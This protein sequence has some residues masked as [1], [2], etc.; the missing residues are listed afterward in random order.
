[1]CLSGSGKLQVE[2]ESLVCYGYGVSEEEEGVCG[3]R[4]DRPIAMNSVLSRTTACST[5]TKPRR[6]R[7]ISAFAVA[8][9]NL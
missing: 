7:G 2:G 5:P 9:S 8:S 4:S 3:G 6:G 1:M